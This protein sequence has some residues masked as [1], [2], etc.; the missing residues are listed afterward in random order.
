MLSAQFIGNLPYLCDIGSFIAA[1]FPAAF[2]GHG[3]PDN[4]VVNAFGVEMGADH[5][6]KVPAE[7]PIRKFQPD[8]VGQFRRYLSGSKAL[9]Q[10][11][12]LHTFFL[13]PHFLDAAHILKS[14]FTGAAESGCEQILLG[15]VFVEGLID[16]PFQRFL[17][18]PAGAFLLVEGI[19]DGV[20][21]AVDGDNAGVGN[22]GFLLS[23]A[24]V[25]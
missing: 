23:W 2:H 24:Q 21:E 3:I 14:R 9:H 11:E 17:V 22:S 18:F 6:L 15:F 10:M 25:A 13:V 20:V 5:R 19:V 8:L 12:A 16:F 4:V 1:V 7:Q